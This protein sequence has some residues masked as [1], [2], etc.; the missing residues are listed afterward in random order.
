MQLWQISVSGCFWPKQVFMGCFFGLNLAALSDVLHLK[1]A[2]AKETFAPPPR[3]LHN[4]ITT[5]TEG[6]DPQRRENEDSAICVF[7][8]CMC[9]RVQG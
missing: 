9:V 6:N 1:A 5:Q 4:F 3:D 7:S 2:V 8:V